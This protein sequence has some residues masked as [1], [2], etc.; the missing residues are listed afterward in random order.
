M[1]TL[2]SLVLSFFFF[3]SFIPFKAAQAS[4]VR[5]EKPTQ[6]LHFLLTQYH[7]LQNYDPHAIMNKWQ[8]RVLNESEQTRMRPESDNN[9]MYGNG[10]RTY[11]E[12]S[13]MYPPQTSQPTTAPQM[14]S[15]PSA[16]SW[17]QGSYN[18]AYPLNPGYQYPPAP[19]PYPAQT[20]PPRPYQPMYPQQ[21]YPQPCFC[22]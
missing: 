11:P 5:K 21:T 20:Y 9:L 22:T 18:P 12:S 2:G 19:S 13:Y 1:R 3:G 7:E 10:S 16:P 4:D 14:Y 6:K 17:P 15:E 8:G